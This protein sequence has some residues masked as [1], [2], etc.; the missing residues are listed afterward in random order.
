MN[1]FHLNRQMAR[2]IVLQRIELLSPFYKK[3][4]KLFGRYL[5]GNFFIK[6]FLSSKKIGESYYHIMNNEIEIIKDHLDLENKKILSI[7]GGMG[8][9]EALLNKKF[10]NNKY[11]FKEKNYISKKVKYGWDPK[12]NEAYNNLDLLKEFLLANGMNQSNF[13]IYDQDKDSLPEVK[14]DIINSLYSLDYHYDFN[15]Y[16]DYIIVGMDES[17]LSKKIDQNEL[18]LQIHNLY[19][20][21]I[22]ICFLKN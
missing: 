6:Y 12:N 21:Q 9:L 5:F 4:R 13:E 14:F 22:S 2:L 18:I 15:I 20:Y 8:G 11:Y 17:L 7:G 1:I 16:I 3:V 10:V 19:C